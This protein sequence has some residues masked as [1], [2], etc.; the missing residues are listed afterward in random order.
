[1]SAKQEREQKY[2]ER[3][4]RKRDREIKKLLRVVN[5]KSVEIKQIQRTEDNTH[6]TLVYN[7]GQCFKCSG[8]LVNEVLTV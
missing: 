8:P 3:Q 5:H 2:L 7:N 1:M 4:Q 6:L